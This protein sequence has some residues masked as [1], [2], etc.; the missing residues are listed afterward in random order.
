MKRP[1]MIT[2]IARQADAEIA[3]H[4]T[5]TALKAALAGL[6]GPERSSKGFG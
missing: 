5:A 1:I 3:G 4:L 6:G 2:D